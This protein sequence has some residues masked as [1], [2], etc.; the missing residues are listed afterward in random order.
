MNGMHGPGD[1]CSVLELLSALAIGQELG[2]APR[3]E[4]TIVVILAGSR[5]RTI[6]N[7]ILTSCAITQQSI[8]YLEI[9]CSD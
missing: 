4:P 9:T 7:G 5:I 6:P 3:I 1:P 2:T 8:E